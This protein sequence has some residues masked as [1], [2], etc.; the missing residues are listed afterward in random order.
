MAVT[1]IWAIRGRLDHVL[2]YAMNEE[3]LREA[4]PDA[5]SIDFA[6]PDY[7]SLY[8]V[9]NYAED[10]SKTEQKLFVSGVNCDPENARA[11]MIATKEQW[12][13]T[14]GIIAFHM[15]QSFRPEEGTPELIH[16]IGVRLAK[17]M[18]GERFE[19]IVATHCNS[20]CLHNHIVANSVSKLDGKRFYD[21]RKTMHQLRE[22]SDRL[23]KEY[24]LS[25]IEKPMSK[26][27]DYSE[28][29]AEKNGAYTKN[30][31]I[32]RDIDECVIIASNNRDFYRLMGARGY[33][34]DFS[35]KYATV[36]HPAFP[37]A[38]RMKTLG[39]EYTPE[40]IRTRIYKKKNRYEIDIPQQ[41]D[42]EQFFFD[43]DRNNSEIFADFRSV[44][45]HF[46][47]GLGKIRERQNYNRDV[48]HLLWEEERIFDKMVEEQNLMLD[49]DLYTDEDIKRYRNE[50]ETEIA[51]VTEAR[52]SMRNSLKR[53]VRAEDSVKQAELRSDISFL[54]GRLAKLRKDIKICDRIL[55]EEPKVAAQLQRVKEYT[56][57]FKRREEQNRDEHIGRRR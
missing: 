7:Q 16:E 54:S 47:F 20:S 9:M 26:G 25:V 53:A 39:E 23:C 4:D 57:K 24:G 19:A 11:E 30:T 1:K 46:V 5:D 29:L 22:L 34:F 18:F 51:E 21:Q 56:E 32:K 6:D 40:A 38:R 13:K 42:P 2:N 3:K 15:Y 14:G 50:A 37:K 33:S 27:K 48:I 44:Y 36:Y 10:E 31:L 52:T 41:D 35:G 28:W 43:G 49:N 45:V 55:V 17:E 8:D 12:N